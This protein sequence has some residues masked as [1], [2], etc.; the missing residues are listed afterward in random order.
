MRSRLGQSG[1]SDPPANPDAHPSLWMGGRPMSAP[2]P[3]ADHGWLWAH[4]M[5]AAMV[6]WTLYK[7]AILHCLPQRKIFIKHPSMYLKQQELP[8]ELCK[9]N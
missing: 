1:P 6:A 8:G 5:A 2:A 4:R 3:S 7:T 9:K